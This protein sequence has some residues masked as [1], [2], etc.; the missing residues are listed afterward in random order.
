MRRR[1]LPI[2]CYFAAK[3]HVAIFDMN[4]QNLIEFLLFASFVQGSCACHV[5]FSC[6]IWFRLSKCSPGARWGFY[7][8]SKSC[9]SWSCRSGSYPSSSTRNATRSS[10][11]ASNDKRTSSCFSSSSAV[12][13][14]SAT[15]S[16]F[17]NRLECFQA[18]SKP[19]NSGPELLLSTS[20]L[21]FMAIYCNMFGREGLKGKGWSRLCVWVGAIVRVRSFGSF[22]SHCAQP[23]AHIQEHDD[24]MWLFK[25]VTK[26]LKATL[27]TST[28]IAP[29]K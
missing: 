29:Q 3:P 10:T 6:F 9:W 24:M 14:A 17:A 12:P 1:D 4:Y 28:V 11:R 2:F 20:K 18:W 16:S 5:C 7:Q 21:K 23:S 26:W 15:V 8:K 25:E 19:D 13:D 22:G 27:P